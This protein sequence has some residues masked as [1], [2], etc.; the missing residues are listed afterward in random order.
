MTFLSR[1]NLLLSDHLPRLTGDDVCVR[2][3]FP[4]EHGLMVK[5]RIE[6]REFL[7]QWEPA[8]PAEF[9]T[10][11]Y[12]ATQLKYNLQE[13]KSGETVPLVILNPEESTVLGVI[14]FTSIV[15]GT[16]QACHLGYALAE[17]LQGSGVMTQ[18]LDLSIEYIFNEAG[19]H[20][21]MANYMPRNQRSAAVLSRLGFRVEGK[22]LKFMKIN[23]LW[24]DHILTSLI[25]PLPSHI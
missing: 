10:T 7:R 24:E 1:K 5:F 19:L 9:F 12:W 18:A 22:A 8:R 23:G 15:R 3:L 4:E 2:L 20:R 11:G 6:N 14:N 13:F 16:F 25:N 17:K 21:I